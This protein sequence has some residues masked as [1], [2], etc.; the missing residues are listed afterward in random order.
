MQ[1]TLSTA[2]R[3]QELHDRIDSLDRRI[4]ENAVALKRLSVLNSGSNE[5]RELLRERGELERKW[6]NLL[7]EY[8]QC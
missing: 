5:L 7:A 4:G 1:A 6:S 8:A 3:K 2:D